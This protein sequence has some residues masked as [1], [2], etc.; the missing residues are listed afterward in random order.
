[1]KLACIFGTRPEIIKLAPV[2]WAA[3]EQDAVDLLLVH[4]GQHYDSSMSGNFIEGLGLPKPHYNLGIGSG[5]SVLQISELMP[6]LEGLFTK[7]RPDVVIFQGDTNTAP[8]TCITARSM[9]IPLVHLEAGLRSFNESSWEEV[10][11]RIAT[12]CSLLH[13]APTEMAR[14][15]LLREGV[16]ATR[17]YVTGNTIV[18]VVSRIKP[19]L[20]RSDLLRGL[21]KKK[22]LLMTIHRSSNTDNDRRLSEVITAAIR[23]SDEYNVVFPIHPRTRKRLESLDRLRELERASGVKI[24][25]PLEYAAFLSLMTSV[26]LV[27]TDSGGVQEEAAVLGKPAVTIRPSTPRWET[28]LINCNTLARPEADSIIR[29]VDRIL[30]G[31]NQRD[32]EAARKFLGEPGVGGR[33]LK[34]ILDHY[35]GGGLNYSEP[36]FADRPKEEIK[37]FLEEYLE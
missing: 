17:V 36:A 34:I 9:S 4:T 18:D 11:R 33:V 19:T 6:K 37:R 25:E 1:M 27:I 31:W 24:T 16:Q 5:S 22:S 26:D 35:R 28:I 30:E 20:S 2:I 7:E 12:A 23:L 29:S 15:M 13:F 21:P 8:A 10:N 3:E 14:R 32:S